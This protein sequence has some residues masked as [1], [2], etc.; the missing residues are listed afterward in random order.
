VNKARKEEMDRI[1]ITQ[2]MLDTAQECGVALEQAMEGLKATNASLDTHQRLARRLDSDSNELYE[3]A[4]YA[5]TSGDEEGARLYLLKRNED[6][7]KLKKILKLCTEEKKR[8]EIM[9][10]NV[11][12]IEQRALEVESLLQ[13]TVSSKSRMNAADFSE[14]F[15]VPVEDPLLKKFRDLGID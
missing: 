10:E 5:M 14:S 12:A 7:G 1:G 3:K 6:Q 11:A 13:R 8:L 9:E 2:D 15:S 4:K